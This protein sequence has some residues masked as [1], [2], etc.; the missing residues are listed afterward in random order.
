[1]TQGAVVKRV[2]GLKLA[3]T[4]TIQ[5]LPRERVRVDSRSTRRN[6]ELQREINFDSSQSL[7]LRLFPF[8]R[9]IRY[10]KSRHIKT[11]YESK[12]QTLQRKNQSDSKWPIR[13]A[14]ALV[15]YTIVGFFVVPCDH[16]IAGACS[17]A[18]HG[19]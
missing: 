5:A 11:G 10:Y 1:M 12:K 19:C 6:A 2:P 4:E 18:C 14:V 7:K 3:R 8:C 15:I 13:I 17:S 9:R 16:K